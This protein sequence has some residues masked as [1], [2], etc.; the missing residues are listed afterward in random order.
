MVFELFDEFYANDRENVSY[1]LGGG[2]K[3]LHYHYGETLKPYKNHL[4]CT[5]VNLGKMMM[6]FLLTSGQVYA[7]GTNK[8]QHFVDSDQDKRYEREQLIPFHDTKDKVE[9]IQT[10]K[11]ITVAVTRKGRV[12][13][14]GEKLKKLLKIKN[15]RFGFYPMPMEDPVENVEE[16]AKADAN[17]E[18]DKKA[19]DAPETKAAEDNKLK[20]QRVWIS[21][22]KGKN[23]YVIYCLFMNTETNELEIYSIGKN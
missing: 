23:N 1:Y 2:H 8:S 6:V 18:G 5:Q 3:N 22:C 12:Y 10:Y 15:E 9:S 4:D 17:Q 7:L 21:R 19:D 20:A 14:V 11:R 13:A 16:E